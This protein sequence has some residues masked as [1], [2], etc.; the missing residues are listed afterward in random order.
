MSSPQA[1]IEGTSTPR[2]QH[3]GGL[4]ATAA[5]RLGVLALV[6][7]AAMAAVAADW[8]SPLRTALV[9][10]FALFVPG[11]ALAELLEIEDRAQRLAIAI[12]ASLAI[13]TLVTV[14][15]LYTGLFSADVACAVIFGLTFVTLVAAVIR[16]LWRPPDRPAA[17]SRHVEP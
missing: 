5:V 15:L 10:G 17:A 12:G 2:E 13:E 1:T 9:I 11:L 8:Q 4:D 6:A 3:P 14:A 7:I 16:G